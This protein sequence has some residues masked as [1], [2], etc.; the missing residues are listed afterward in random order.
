MSHPLR[1]GHSY[2]TE[3]LRNKVRLNK[4]RVTDL[5]RSDAAKRETPSLGSVG[6]DVFLPKATRIS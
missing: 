2:S 6:K 4:D 3:M 5:G 1:F